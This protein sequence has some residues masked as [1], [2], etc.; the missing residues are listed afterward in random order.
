MPKIDDQDQANKLLIQSSGSR[1]DSDEDKEKNKKMSPNGIL[2]ALSYL[3]TH[4]A[5]RQQLEKDYPKQEDKDAFCPKVCEKVSPNLF[6]RLFADHILR[7]KSLYSG[8]QVPKASAF[9]L[10]F[11]KMYL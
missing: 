2:A 3:S 8:S 9:L 6:R 10:Y 1:K 7:C 11:S 5:Y 4:I